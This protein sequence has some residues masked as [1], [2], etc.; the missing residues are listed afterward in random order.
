MFQFVN[1]YNSLFYISFVK[2]SLEGCIKDN[3][4]RELEIQ[5]ATI[6]IT[7][8]FMNVFELATPFLMSKIKN[9]SEERRMQKKRERHPDRVY[10][11]EMTDTEAQSKLGAYETP[12]SDYME[13]VIQYGYVALFSAAFTLAPLLAY[14]LNLFEIRVDAW[15]MCYLTRRPFPKRAQDIGIWFSII[16]CIAY[17]GIITNVA[18][19]IFTAHVFDTDLSN[20]WLIFL[21][22]EHCLFLFKYL[23][24]LMIPD[25]PFKVEKALTWQ[26]RIVN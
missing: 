7:N 24:S 2:S 14:I 18:I 9:W 22:L 3:C 26:S 17:A 20:K 15:K 19:A 21:I 23:L 13:M 6:F 1:S 25:T 4:M 10:R 5:L 8:M 12:M 16:Q 11:T